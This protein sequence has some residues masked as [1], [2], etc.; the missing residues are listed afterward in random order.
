MADA[1]D[2][3]KQEEPEAPEKND[4]KAEADDKSTEKT[5]KETKTDDKEASHGGILQWI[6]MAVIVVICAA[7]GFGLSRLLAGPEK[8]ET[9]E[10]PEKD[11]STNQ[12]I[13]NEDSEAD[14]KET[15]YY[16]LEPVVA[17]LD[18]PGVTRYVRVTLTLEISPALN[19]E[20]GTAI[21][22]VKKPILKNWLTIYLASLTLEDTR[23]DRNLKR[24]QSQILDAFNEK[25][26]PDAKP[27]IKHILFKEFAVQ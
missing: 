6:I 16:D 20:K 17:N 24:I 8:T 5:G 14:S 10:S 3:K 7:S 1:D 22:E 21:I 13:S 12:K 25:L 19:Q 18:V 26:F 4:K 27:Q 11:E 9:A 2:T 15:W 23:G